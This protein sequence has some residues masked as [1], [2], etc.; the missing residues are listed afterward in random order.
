MLLNLSRVFVMLIVFVMNRVSNEGKEASADLPK[1]IY[2]VLYL[3]T[4]TASKTHTFLPFQNI[5]L[6]ITQKVIEQFILE[7]KNPKV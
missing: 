1:V 3:P 4:S 7:G 2:R 5:A 6:L